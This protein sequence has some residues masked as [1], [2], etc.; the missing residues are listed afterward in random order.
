MTVPS[1][2]RGKRSGAIRS[3]TASSHANS[4]SATHEK[5]SDGERRSDWAEYFEGL[6]LRTMRCAG[7]Q[8][9]TCALSL[10]R[11][12]P[13]HD[14]ADFIFYDQES[15]TPELES[16]LRQLPPLAPIAYARS[17]RDARGR[18]FPVATDIFSGRRPER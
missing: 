1:S 13:L 11:R 14:E 4:A 10:E 7:P 18:Q 12:C 6:G 5:S 2:S 9:T 15:L 3:S 8:A 16:Q 17:E